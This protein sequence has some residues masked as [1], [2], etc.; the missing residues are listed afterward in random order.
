MWPDT[1]LLD[2]FGI[3][4]PIIQAPMLGSAYPV[5]GADEQAIEIARNGLKPFHE[6]LGAGPVPEEL[7]QPRLGFSTA[8]ASMLAELSPP[9][10]SFHFGVCPALKRSEF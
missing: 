5:L 2:L 9:V 3:D 4:H 10:V 1:R 6:E 8:R 7:P